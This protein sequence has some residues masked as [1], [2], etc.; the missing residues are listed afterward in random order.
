MTENNRKQALILAG[1]EVLANHHGMAPGMIFTKN[2]RTYILLPGPPKELEPMFQFEAKPKLAAMLN[3]GGIIASHVMR[4]YGIGEAELEVQVQ[5]ILDAQT[6]PTVAPL[7]SDGE[8][9]LRV[10]AKAATE[11]QAR[12]LIKAKVAEIQAL[13]GDY[14]YGVDDDSL[15][16]KTV[17]MLLDNKLTIAAAES[18]TGRVISI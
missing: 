2:D 10:T 4:F 16:S 5:N 8:V 1:S 9:T 3:D 11:Q 14:Q 12:Q 18:L 7:A 6:N 17:E 13:V 15:A